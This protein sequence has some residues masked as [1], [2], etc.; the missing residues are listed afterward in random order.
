MIFQN[1]SASTVQQYADNKTMV[2]CDFSKIHRKPKC[3][4]DLSVKIKYHNYSQIK[5]YNT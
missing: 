3:R 1:L 4:S 5:I 2:Y